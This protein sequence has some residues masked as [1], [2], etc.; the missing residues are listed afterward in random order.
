MGLRHRVPA[1]AI[2]SQ[3][4]RCPCC[5]SRRAVLAGLGAAAP[6]FTVLG[7]PTTAQRAG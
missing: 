7:A 1:A 6:G 2:N 4:A 3:S 5:M